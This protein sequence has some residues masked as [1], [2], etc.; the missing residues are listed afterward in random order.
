[1]WTFLTIVFVIA[2]I[3]VLLLKENEHKRVA[4][5]EEDLIENDKA[6]KRSLNLEKNRQSEL[7]NQLLVE[8]EAELQ[9]Q[10]EKYEK[11]IA[12][13]Q[14]LNASLQNGIEMYKEQQRRA[15][16]L[17]PDLETEIDRMIKEEIVKADIEKANEFDE[18]ANKV[19]FKP[20]SRYIVEELKNVLDVYSKLTDAQ[21]G[22]VTT[23]VEKLSYLY[24]A[25]SGLQKAYLQKQEEEKNKRIATNT[26]NQID[27][28][29]SKITFVTRHDL[30][31]LNV[32]MRLYEELEESYK[33]YFDSTIMPKVYELMQQAKLDERRY[34]SNRHIAESYD[35]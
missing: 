19:T 26:Y 1:M 18:V 31:Q 24:Q 3:I 4:K 30:H 23:D 33:A 5:L 15:L 17:H 28:I 32:A 35:K 22:Y 11:E 29:V 14:E 9:D 27:S 10:K 34:I 12:D 8:D 25:S 16:I 2:F 21:K 6:Y 13:L 7:Y 20:A